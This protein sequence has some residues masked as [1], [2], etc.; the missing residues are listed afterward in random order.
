MAG[1]LPTRQITLSAK[2][3][4]QLC[5]SRVSKLW[6]AHRGRRCVT[7]GQAEEL[8]PAQWPLD[9]EIQGISQIRILL[10]IARPHKFTIMIHAKCY[11]GNKYQSILPPEWAIK[12]DTHTERCTKLSL[13][14]CGKLQLIQSKLLYD[15]Q[16][17]SMSW[18]RSPL[19]DLRQ[20]IT[21][22]RNVTVWNFRSC[23]C[24]KPSLTRGRVEGRS[25][26]RTD[27]Q[28]VSQYVLVSSTLVGLATSKLF[29]VGMLLSEICGLLSVGIPLWREDG[30]KVEVTLR[31]T[32]SQSVCLGIEH[33]CGT[34]DQ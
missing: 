1:A 3:W 17:V 9:A 30:S 31:L 33:P 8:T 26:F 24:G 6:H 5:C 19:W 29:P 11:L 21:S 14:S 20:D 25:Y 32:V 18:Y 34:C 23:F 16:S 7:T 28:S 22:C 15:R 13:N 10:S 4:L 2:Q 12:S 27:G